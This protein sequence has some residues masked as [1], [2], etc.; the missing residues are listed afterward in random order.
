MD[1]VHFTVD[2]N[3]DAAVPPAGAALTDARKIRIHPDHWYPVAWS[4]ELKAG[5]TLA[6]RFSGEPVVLVRPKDGTVFAL[7][8][9][10]AHRQVPLS[11]GMVE[12]CA[13]RCGY[14]GWIYDAAGACT[15]VPYLGKDT[16][17]GRLPNGVRAYPCQRS[18]TA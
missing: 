11:K 12:G 13:I 2:D 5:K 16:G 17:Q 4:T 6:V 18:R 9:R 10:C 15:D 8:N 3:E 14:H 1:S 7:E